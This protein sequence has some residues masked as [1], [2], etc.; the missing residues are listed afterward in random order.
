[1]GFADDRFADFHALVEE[2]FVSFFDV[3]GTHFRRNGL[4]V[5][6][7]VGG[8]LGIA[9]RKGRGGR[10]GSLVESLFPSG[11]IADPNVSSCRSGKSP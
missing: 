5:S 8:G 1:M 4:R 6:I 3:V 9:A 11:A 2:G 10:E 7:E